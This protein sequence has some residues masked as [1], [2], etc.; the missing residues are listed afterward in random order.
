MLEIE[1]PFRA[2][3]ALFGRLCE[4]PYAQ[5]V[6]PLFYGQSL[7]NRR[8]GAVRHRKSSSVP[9]TLSIIQSAPA[10]RLQVGTERSESGESNE[11]K[12]QSDNCRR[13]SL[14]NWPVTKSH[15]RNELTRA[16]SFAPNRR[17][18]ATAAR[19]DAVST[20][21]ENTKMYKLSLSKKCTN[22][23]EI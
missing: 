14:L 21:H 2:G 4:N 12:V 15:A 5:F 13:M 9:F 7:P 10:A 16:C 8:T 6:R 11:S 22:V 1:F 18:P 20:Q 23:N 17:S 19:G 3:S